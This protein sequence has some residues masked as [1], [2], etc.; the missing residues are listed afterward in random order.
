[1]KI[2]RKEIKKIS[3]S[4]NSISNRVMRSIYGEYI[5]TLKKFIKFIEEN[6]LIND[7][8][9]SC[10]C[11]TNIEEECKEVLRYRNDSK[12]SFGP[13][14]NEESYQIY[15]LLKYLVC[16]KNDEDLVYGLYGSYEG[17]NKNDILKSF[18]DRVIYILISNIESYLTEMMIDMGLDEESTFIVSGGQVNIA[19][20]NSTINVTQNNGIDE[21][22]LDKLITVI[23]DNISSLEEENREMLNDTLELVK[24]EL[25]KQRPKVSRLKNCVTLLS[26]IMGIAVNTPKLVSG[27]S[28]LIKYINT[29]IK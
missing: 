27:I 13:T 3:Y 2:N 22:E 9:N 17:K 29:I 5:D 12:F 21:K 11:E 6:E 20:D 23:T 25:S 19:N 18:S 10:K 26:P 7:Y 15:S 1:M 14:R 4:F 16:N 8:I 28:N 24:E